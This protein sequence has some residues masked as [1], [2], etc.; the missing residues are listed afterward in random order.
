MPC[1]VIS[2]LNSSLETNFCYGEVNKENKMNPSY[3]QSR[4]PHDESFKSMEL[5]RIVMFRIENLHH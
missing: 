1:P 5:E 2:Q 4:K 3:H